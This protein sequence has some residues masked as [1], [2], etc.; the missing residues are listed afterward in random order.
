MFT[1]AV[2]VDVAPNGRARELAGMLL[3]WTPSLTSVVG[4]LSNNAGAPIGPRTFGPG[5]YPYQQSF[6]I[7]IGCI[8][9]YPILCKKIFEFQS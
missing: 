6:L 9:M 8:L 2:V 4:P 7:R 3:D 1:G 5:V